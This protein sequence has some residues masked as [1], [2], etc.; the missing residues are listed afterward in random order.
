MS[1]LAWLTPDTPP[2]DKLTRRLRF[3]N[4]VDFL[5]IV[6]GA[7]LPLTKPENFEQYGTLTPEET[8]AYFQ[9]MVD[10]F[11]MIQGSH[12][13]GEVFIWP[14]ENV[15]HNPP[16]YATGDVLRCSG[17]LL[18]VAD[19]PELYAVIGT[20]YTGDDTQFH[21][22]NFDGRFLFQGTAG[23][24]GGEA[25]HTL[26]LDEM[27]SH[28]HTESVALPSIGAAITGVPVP[29]A[30]P[31]VNATSPNG[32]SAPHNNMPPF[33]SMGYFIQAR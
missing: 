8:A 1:R 28:Y 22:P 12:I 32:G 24:T 3:P 23:I 5:A 33:L 4:S 31:G 14:G 15:S 29:S 9:T 30:V 19:Y 21:L 10:E 18:N 11:A 20:T 27:P 17:Q 6:M 13:V 16:G 2:S 25:V 26:S 7:L